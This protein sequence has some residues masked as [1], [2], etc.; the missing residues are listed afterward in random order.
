MVSD[1]TSISVVLPD[2]EWL[3]ALDSYITD[4]SLH[5]SM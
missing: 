3:K 5:L 4:F 1:A 2:S